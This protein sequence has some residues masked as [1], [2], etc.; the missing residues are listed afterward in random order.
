VE[1]VIRAAQSLGMAT[2]AD[3]VDGGRQLAVMKA[4]GA[5]AA[6]GRF[7]AGPMG[8]DAAR[9]LAGAD[10]VPRFSR[11]EPRT[12]VPAEPRPGP[13]TPPGEAVTAKS[14]GGASKGAASKKGTGAA[15]RSPAK[16]PA[17]GVSEED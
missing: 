15:R 5:D 16:R 6:Q 7:F 14:P 9:S 1:A 11:T 10:T 8:P 3:G 2:I 12:V 4:L 13:S 17:S